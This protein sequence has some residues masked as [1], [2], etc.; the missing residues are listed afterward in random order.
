MQV[1]DQVI[2]ILLID[3][4]ADY[5]AM[6]KNYLQSFNGKSFRLTW[7]DD[8]E[9]VLSY[10]KSPNE[11]H[12]ILMDYYLKTRN[13]LEILKDLREAGVDLP[14]IMLT[15]GKDFR[16]AVEAMKYG[17]VDY[18]VKEEVVDTLFPRSIVNALEQ[19]DLKTQISTAEK[20]KVI[21]QRK[22]E[23]VQ[24]LIVTMCHEFNNPLAAIKISTDI[25]TRQCKAPDVKALLSELNRNISSLEKQIVTLRDMNVPPRVPS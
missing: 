3:D 24:E 12:I 18:L 22:T 4:D 17:V 13:G 5:A 1:P 11:I 14:V 7:M 19:Q 15:G 16:I 25:L 2:N 20:N 21:S 23:A 10:L 8:G 9:K 6:A